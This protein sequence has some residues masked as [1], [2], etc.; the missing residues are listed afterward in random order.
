MV[1]RMLAYAVLL[2]LAIAGYA[3]APAWVVPVAAACLTLAEWRPW[4]LE[5][6]TRVPGSSKATTYLVS[7]AI[8]HL[9]LAILAFGVGRILHRVLG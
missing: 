5:R 6:R 1:H 4:R 9:V 7:G 2:G 8:L 3:S